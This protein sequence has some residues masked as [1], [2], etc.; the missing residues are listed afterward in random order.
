MWISESVLVY[1]NR[2]CFYRATSWKKS[3][4]NRSTI[5]WAFSQLI[6][7]HAPN[8][9]IIFY[10]LQ[11][12]KFLPLVLLEA[13][14][15]SDL[16]LILTFLLWSQ[17]LLISFL[18]LYWLLCPR[19]TIIWAHDSSLWWVVASDRGY[20]II[21]QPITVVNKQT[22]G[23]DVINKLALVCTCNYIIHQFENLGLF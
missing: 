22:D 23:W 18:Y 17:V 21:A 1:F 2:I 5:Y 8:Y 19:N 10:L 16:L 20:D 3:K 6:I 9:H 13:K 4:S 12:L 15:I 14:N 7:M 11:L